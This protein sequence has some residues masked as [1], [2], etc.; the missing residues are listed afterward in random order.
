LILNSTFFATV[1][2]RFGIENRALVHDRNPTR[3][4]AASDSGRNAT[5]QIRESKF[6]KSRLLPLNNDFAGEIEHYLRARARRKLPLS[7]DTALIWNGRKGVRAYS[8]RGLQRNLGLLLQQCSI[9]TPKGRLP[10]IH[11]FRRSGTAG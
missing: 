7:S 10:R 11:D 1:A 9:F 8:V 5:L 2:N 6:H 3:G 4:V